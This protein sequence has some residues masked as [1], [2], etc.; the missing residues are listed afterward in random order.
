[1]LHLLE[2]FPENH[3][4]QGFDS[5]STQLITP[6]NGYTSSSQP[7]VILAAP[8]TTVSSQ[9]S[10]FYLSEIAQ[11]GD[12]NGDGFDDLLISSPFTVTTNVTVNDQGSVFVVFGGN[13][14]GAKPFDL[15][16]LSANQQN[17]GSSVYGFLVNGLPNAQAGFA[18][19]GDSD[20]N[21]DGFDDLAIGAPGSYESQLSQNTVIGDSKGRIWYNGQQINGGNSDPAVLSMVAQENASG[22]VSQIVVGLVN[23]EVWW[24]NGST[25]SQLNSSDIVNDWASPINTLSVQWNEQGQ[26]PQVIVGLGGDGGVFLF[27]GDTNNWLT[28]IDSAEG[29]PVTQMAVNWQENPPQVVVG[30]QDGTVEYSVD[31]TPD[32]NTFPQPSSSNSSIPITQLAVNWQEN[33]DPQIV[34]GLGDKGG[35]E[36]YDGSNWIT[37]QNQGWGSSVTQMSVQWG[38]DGQPQ[39]IVGL[40]DGAVISMTDNGSGWTQTNLLTNKPTITQMAV[41][42][43]ADGDPQIVAALGGQGGVEYYNGS[44]WITV[45]DSELIGGNPV[46]QMSAQWGSDGQPQIIVGLNDGVAIAFSY[47]G[48]Q[49]A[50][51]TIAVVNAG[52]NQLTSLWSESLV[53]TGNGDN[54]SY[55]LFGDDFTHTVTQ[56]GTIGADVMLGTATGESFLAGQGDDQIYGQGGVDVVYA[57]PGDDLVTVTDT[58]FRRLDGGTGL[59]TLQFTGYNGQAWNLTTLSPGLRLQDFEILD[60]RNYGANTLTLN[61]VTVSQLSSNNTLTLFMDGTDSLVLSA[62][63]SQ[64]GTVYQYDQNF[65][66]FTSSSSAATVLLN[67][68][69]ANVTLT[70][71]SANTPASIPPNES[72]AAPAMLAQGATLGTS[73]QS[74]DGSTYL[75]S[76]PKSIMNRFRLAP[77]FPRGFG[78][79]NPWIAFTTHLGLLY[80]D[81]PIVS[82]ASGEVNFTIQ[83]TG[84]LSQYLSVAYQTQDGDGK[85]GDR[86]LPVAGQLTFNPGET[87]KTVSVPIPNHGIYTGDRQFVLLITRLETGAEAWRLVVD[88]QGAQIRNWQASPENGALQFAA[89]ASTA[90]P[91]NLEFTLTGTEPRALPR[92]WNT[93]SQSFTVP[94]WS[95]DNTLSLAYDPAQSR[96]TYRL[97]LEEGGAFD[98]DGA[99]NGL[100]NLSVQMP[101]L[102][103]APA[104]L[105]RERTEGTQEGDFLSAAGLTGDFHPWGSDFR[106]WGL[107]GNDLLLGSEQRDLLQGNFADDQLFGQ[108][109]VDRLYGGLGNDYLDGGRERDFLH[110]GKGSD[111]FVLRLGEE[112]DQLLD[113][114]PLEG[115]RIALDQLGFSDLTFSANQILVGSTALALVF[116]QQGQPLTDWSAGS[117]WFIFL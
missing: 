80:V 63:F 83:R 97:Q 104:P 101:A 50:D 66:Q 113:F 40:N 65:L 90:T 39:I 62:D 55:V 43:N 102:A 2:K 1:V 88:P 75:Y 94:S 30:Y 32:T 35:V 12:V 68:P 107:R 86:Y 74:G 84:D 114:N 106:L 6:L 49:W 38:S 116:D 48:S 100:L 112:T 10:P 71:P 64:E 41:Q 34:I 46:T 44:Q 79:D 56:T 95:G 98:A 60:T 22:G 47:N 54:L 109:G 77:P 76:R 93:E 31:T 19:S 11:A 70:A 96:Q 8:F 25:W 4:Q 17:Q 85:A 29:S 27:N 111:L 78:G 87:T 33:G 67:I 24:Y 99:T 92:F 110:G 91:V 15:G 28:L 57:G 108:S 72:P 73:L 45:A 61:A 59:D 89:T 69:V 23:G 14:W 13:S 52:I 82:E 51:N 117:P 103:P 5:F 3:I 16:Q 105:P 42:W 58:Y 20:V 26:S 115:D 53:N 7:D 37:L 81:N 9:Q 36:Y 21:G 18:I